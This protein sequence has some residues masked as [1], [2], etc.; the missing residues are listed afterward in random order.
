MQYNKNI[1]T[2]NLNEV[3]VKVEEKGNILEVIPLNLSLSLNLAILNENCRIL[4]GNQIRLV[5][6]NPVK[7]KK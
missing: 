2:S 7:V 1:P 5:R 3:E 4:T 6:H